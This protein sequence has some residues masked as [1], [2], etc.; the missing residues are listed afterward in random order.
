MTLPQALTAS[1][2]IAAPPSTVFGYLV[3]P[4]LLVRWIGE[5][6]DLDPRPGGVFSL[7]VGAAAV[8]GRFVAVEPPTRVVFTWGVP[9]SATIPPGS[10]TVEIL[11]REDGSDTVVDLVHHDLPAAEQ[12]GHLAGWVRCLDHLVLA[13]GGGS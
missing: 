9:G 3:D 8:R 4:A 6:A 2:R 1:V 11:L 7:D 10:T 13:L 5:W 12:P